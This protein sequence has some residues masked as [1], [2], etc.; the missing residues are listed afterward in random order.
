MVSQPSAPDPYATAA[1]QG[2]Q[3]QI[4]SQYNT[5]S[6]N[7]NEVNPY[8]TVSYQAMEQ[9]PIYTNGQ[10]SGYAPRYQRTTTLSPDQQKL[11]GL[12]TQSKYNMGTTAVEQSANLRDHLN[13][14]KLDPSQWTQWQTGL[15]GGT[16]R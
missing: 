10:I 13:N 1:A 14:N 16:L 8:G 11:L 15:Q 5:A 2:Q 12:E 3:N 9:V 6:G 7:V 4:A